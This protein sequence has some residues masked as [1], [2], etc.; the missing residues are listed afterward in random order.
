M[1]R[2]TVSLHVSALLSV[3]LFLVAAS[4]AQR[5]GIYG[6]LSREPF[7]IFDNLYYVGIKWVSA[8][9]LDTGDGLILLDTLYGKTRSTPDRARQLDERAYVSGIKHGESVNLNRQIG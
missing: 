1:K 9:V 2:S 7:K 6:S 4:Y 3:T 8:W 5:G